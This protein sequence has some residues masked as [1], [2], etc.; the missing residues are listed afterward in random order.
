M[1]NISDLILLS[2]K[3]IMKNIGLFIQQTR[4]KQNLTQ[5]EVAFQAAISRSTLSLVE[6][7]DNISLVNLIK[8]LRTLNALY[9][10]QTFEVKE[11]LSPLQLA[12]GEKQKRQRASK[13]KTDKQDHTDLGW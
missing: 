8:I 2:D 3:A 6:R 13:Q 5:E 10:L 7:G 1:A 9:V 4:I 12:K 11:E